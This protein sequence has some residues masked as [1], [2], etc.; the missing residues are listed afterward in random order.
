MSAS[1][2]ADQRDLGQV[3]ALAQQVHADEH[4][5]L[6]EPQLAD[7]LDPLQRVDLRVQVADLEAHL[8]QVV[9]EVLAH[10]LRE[11]R[12]EHALV[13]VHARA[14]LAHQVV[15]LV[16]RLAHLDLRVHDPRRPDDL[17]DDRRRVLA[18]VRR[19]AWP[20][21]TRAAA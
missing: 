12:D 17:L 14:D 6:A 1:R 9:R 11:R 19:P 2:I 3:Q 10:L 15:D 20:R 5:V 18:L 21:R 4:V 13:A 7:D 8:E 16:A